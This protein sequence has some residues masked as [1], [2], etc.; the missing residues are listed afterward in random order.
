MAKQIQGY[1]IHYPAPD[2]V[3]L[4]WM[5]T[6][7]IME[8]NE[9]KA[10]KMQTDI[11][12]VRE[13]EYLVVSGFKIYHVLWDREMGSCSCPEWTYNTGE[14]A[15]PGVPIIVVR[16]MIANHAEQIKPLTK[17]LRDLVQKFCTAEGIECKLPEI[18]EEEPQDDKTDEGKDVFR[19]PP[20][21]KPSPKSEHVYGCY[22]CG[23]EIT[24]DQRSKSVK[25]HGTALCAACE[26]SV[27][28]K[29]QDPQKPK[30]QKQKKKEPENPP[31]KEVSKE[32]SVP[33]EPDV[34]PARQEPAAPPSRK[35][36]DAEVD[37]Q[38]EKAKAKRYLQQQGGSYKVRGIER[39]DAAQI[40]Y[41]ANEEGVA[42]TIIKAEQ[43]DKY[44][45]VVVRGWLVDKPSQTI[46]AVVHHDFDTE[47]MLKTMEIAAKNPGILDHYDGTVPVIKDGAKII[48]YEE[49]KRIEKDAKYYLVHALLSFKKFAIRDSCTKAMSIVEMK[50]LNKDFRSD[51]ER[52]SEQEEKVLVEKSIKNRQ[53]MKASA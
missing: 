1:S 25:A 23:A 35:L 53:A 38:I 4:M 51:E 8:E 9:E 50:L 44:A 46:E 17:D 14:P 37:N 31:V 48:E 47:L 16:N 3:A 45:E 52:A 40:Q 13:N 43:T 26:K 32:P 20:T 18:Q 10:R 30:E 33:K 28:D 27:E 5:T 2:P 15:I 42:V 22:S 19:P 12:E 6:S 49:G 7:K 34:L 21:S 24:A 11:Y 36:S 39:P 29:K 41:I